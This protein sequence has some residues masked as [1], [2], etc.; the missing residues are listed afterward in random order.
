[1]DI[2]CPNC[3]EP[4]DN[5][6]LHWHA[7]DFDSTY[8]EVRKDFQKRGCE[9]LDAKCV[10]GRTNQGAVA[11]EIHALMGDDLDGVASMMEDAQGLGLL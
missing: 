10:P 9:A 11:A 7:R 5:D 1:M 6:E 8:D 4:W 2:P 3:G